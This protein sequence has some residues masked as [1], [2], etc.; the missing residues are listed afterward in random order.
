MHST[1]WTPMSNI[2]LMNNSHQ[3][4]NYRILPFARLLPMA[5]FSLHVC[6]QTSANFFLRMSATTFLASSTVTP[7]GTW[8]MAFE[9]V[10]QIAL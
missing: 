10:L 9:R 7:L 5:I 3:L 6:I 1:R 2:K 4:K 8:K